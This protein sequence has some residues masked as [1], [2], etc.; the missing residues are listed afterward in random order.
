MD[1]ILTTIITGLPNIAV[2]IWVIWN[3]RQTIKALLDVQQKMLESLMA[4]H[5]P[6]D[7]D[8]S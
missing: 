5:P 2:A 3:D 8:K 7:E 6:Q 1:S 4:L